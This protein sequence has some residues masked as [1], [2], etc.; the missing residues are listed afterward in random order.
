M[1][2]DTI[3]EWVV[4]SNVVVAVTVSANQLLSLDHLSVAFSL[5]NTSELH[6]VALRIFPTF[7]LLTKIQSS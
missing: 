7:L 6:T 5:V 3:G 2:P 4:Q 1:I